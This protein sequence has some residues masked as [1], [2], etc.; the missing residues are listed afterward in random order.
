MHHFML[1]NDLATRY[2]RM[3]FLCLHRLETHRRGMSKLAYSD[4]E[5][6]T[7]LLMDHFTAVTATATQEFRPIGL[8]LDKQFVD[9]LRDM[10]AILNSDRSRIDR[11]KAHVVGLLAGWEKDK[12][13]SL[14]SKF[15]VLIKT[16]LTIGANISNPRD[17]RQFFVTL[18]DDIGELLEKQELTEKEVSELFVALAGGFDAKVHQVLSPSSRVQG[19]IEKFW[20]RFVDVV[21]QCILHM[22]TRKILKVS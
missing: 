16:L 1:P 8:T 3:A 13:K 5:A 9:T 6:I 17:F 14:E 2:G 7:S 12:I 19:R 21:R 11:L 4:L 10:K 15:A 22:Y 20:P 18:A